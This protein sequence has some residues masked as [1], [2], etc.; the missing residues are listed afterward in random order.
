MTQRIK[1]HLEEKVG[2]P[3][4]SNVTYSAGIE[5]DIPDDADAVEALRT[6]GAEVE[7]VLAEYRQATDELLK[8]AIK[9]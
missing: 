6:A 1:I 7:E 4:Y 3:N 8:E 2:F 9:E 5:R